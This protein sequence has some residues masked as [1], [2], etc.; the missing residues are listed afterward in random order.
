MGMTLLLA[1]MCEIFCLILMSQLPMFCLFVNV[2]CER[3]VNE[4]RQIPVHILMSLASKYPCVLYPI[5]KLTV[6]SPVGKS[7]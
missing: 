6:H 7:I 4:V 1:K 2:L 3:N 5:V